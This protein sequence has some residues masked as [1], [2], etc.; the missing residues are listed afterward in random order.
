M[1]IY[2]FQDEVF[3]SKDEPT[4]VD[5]QCVKDGNMAIVDCKDMSLIVQEDNDE[6]VREKI[7]EA[8][9]ITEPASGLSY[10]SPI[11]YQGPL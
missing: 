3:Y 2:L 11:K 7:E 10:H 4:Q 9:L 8:I 5:L 1:Y 6:V